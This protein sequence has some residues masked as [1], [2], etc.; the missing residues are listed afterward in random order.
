MA[1]YAWR[2]TVSQDST[3]SPPSAWAPGHR[4]HVPIG[5]DA[6]RGDLSHGKQHMR[7]KGTAGVGRRS[8]KYEF[9]LKSRLRHWSG[10]PHFVNEPR[11]D[12]LGGKD[13]LPGV[14]CDV[15]HL[16]EDELTVSDQFASAVRGL[17]EFIWVKV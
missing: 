4:G 10:L 8:H 17:V 6:S 2:F 16:V 14:G 7:L 3:N 5:G 9:G 11:L 13:D 12:K 15:Q 1:G